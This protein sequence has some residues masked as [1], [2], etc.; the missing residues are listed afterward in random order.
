M[1]TFSRK[2]DM[3]V[4]FGGETSSRPFP[5]AALGLLECCQSSVPA[6]AVQ[7]GLW[8]VRTSKLS[9]SSL[10]FLIENTSFLFKISFPWE[11]QAAPFYH[12]PNGEKEKLQ[13]IQPRLSIFF[14]LIPIFSEGSES[15]WEKEM[16]W[17]HILPGFLYGLSRTQNKGLLCLLSEIQNLG[18]RRIVDVLEGRSSPDPGEYSQLAILFKNWGWEVLL[19]FG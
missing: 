12:Q 4:P 15:L 1:W 3:T 19:T 13:G 8:S 18:Y 5:A 7:P 17:S 10:A 16:L 2:W 14:Q 9:K 6:K 11:H